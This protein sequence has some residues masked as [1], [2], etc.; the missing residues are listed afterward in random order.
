MQIAQQ[1]VFFSNFFVI[2]NVFFFLILRLF[3]K[4]NKFCIDLWHLSNKHDIILII[5]EITSNQR[6]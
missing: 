3:G 5:W 1:P 4:S 6:S 2:L